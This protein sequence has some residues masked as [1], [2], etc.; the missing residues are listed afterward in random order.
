[1]RESLEIHSQRVE[2]KFERYKKKHKG[3]LDWMGSY[4]L[5]WAKYYS[6]WWNR[7]RIGFSNSDELEEV[8]PIPNDDQPYNEQL[9]SMSP[10]QRAGLE[11]R[12][13]VFAKKVYFE[14]E[15]TTPSKKIKSKD[16]IPQKKVKLEEVELEKPVLKEPVIIDW[17]QNK[18]IVA[19]ES[20]PW[21]ITLGDNGADPRVI[22]DGE[23]NPDE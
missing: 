5:Q 2:K 8:I 7:D 9:K 16:K 17:S 13:W 21:G 15:E 4:I 11:R 22:L 14:P 18:R 12:A 3:L 6:A 19:R 23:E 20:N 10:K 1:M